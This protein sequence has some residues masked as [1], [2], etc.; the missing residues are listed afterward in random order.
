MKTA[1]APSLL[2]GLSVTDLDVTILMPCLN[3][4][5]TLPACIETAREAGDALEAKG[6]NYEILMSD[7][8]S[9][10]GSIELAERLGCRVVHCPHRG[11]G[12]AL[13][14]GCEQA[15]GSYIVFGDS[16]ASYDFREGVPMVDKLREG[17]DVCMGS[18]FKGEIKDGAM[19]WK[20]RYIGN[21]V[22]TGLLNLFYHSGLS[23]A[24]CGLRSMTKEA[25][26]KLR[27]ESRG[28]E[29]ASEMVVK[30]AIMDVKRTEVPVT[31]SKDGRDRAPHL[32]PWRDGWRH[33]KFLLTLCPLWIYFLP[34]AVLMSASLL[35]CAAVL[36]TPL[37]EV[38]KLGPLWIGDHW[39]ILA[40][41]FFG[42]GYQSL[43]MGFAA[44]KY[45]RA[46]GFRKKSK[47]DATIDRLAK[48]D[49]MIGAAV[50]L[51]LVGLGIIS[52]VVLTWSGNHF[53]SL[54]MTRQMIV[55][56]T[57]IVASFQTLFGGFLLSMLGCDD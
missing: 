38:F 6:L 46:L 13:I 42:I 37:G 30:A 50:V 25:F 33:V 18:R 56:T 48:V 12:S 16:D 22:L 5:Q 39:L 20:N 57:L 43:L 11:Y 34:A 44:N 45:T 17:Y 28:M 14:F 35:I 36:Q 49:S 29:F 32:R 7:N 40:G 21:P 31:L 8:G 19:P 55:G 23:D 3:E 51:G 47:Y 2:L 1:L 52:H 53:G 41:G 26:Y 15:R 27:L 9:T 10:D 24:H 54:Q 4:V